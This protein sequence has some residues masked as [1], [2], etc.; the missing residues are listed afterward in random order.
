MTKIK[1][2]KKSCTPTSTREM[3]FR[4]SVLLQTFPLLLLTVREYFSLE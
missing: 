2:N 1:H 4:K 3:L